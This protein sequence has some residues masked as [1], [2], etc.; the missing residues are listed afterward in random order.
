MR[1]EAEVENNS[2][3][4]KVLKFPFF[5]GHGNPVW[6]S[7]YSTQELVD[8]LLVSIPDPRIW[9]SEF[10]LQPVT[11]EYRIVQKAWIKNYSTLP[12]LNSWDYHS[13]VIAIDPAISKE[14]TADNTGMVAAH[15]FN[16]EGVWKAYILPNP[17]NSKFDSDELIQNATFMYKHIEGNNKKV[18]T[19]N[20]GF[21]EMLA[22]QLGHVIPNVQSVSHG[23]IAKPDRLGSVANLIKNGVVLWPETGC[24]ILIKQVV[25]FGFTR[26][27]DLA[28]ALAY[29]L[30]YLSELMNKPNNDPIS[31]KSIGLRPRIF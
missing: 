5:D 6:K 9:E 17:I 23:G 30:I 4:G 24:E 12:E 18:L 22:I 28:D 11:A 20:S 16:H 19:E 1:M 7:K 15:I 8:D 31:V 26:Y 14:P 21:Q 10:M 27:D 29:I 25:D 13:T 2:K 3:F